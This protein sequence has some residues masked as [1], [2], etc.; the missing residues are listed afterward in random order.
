MATHGRRIV[1]AGLLLLGALCAGCDST[2]IG[3]LLYFLGPE[4]K[5]EP[6][7]RR[8]A[9]EDKSKESKVVLLVSTRGLEVRPELIQADR[10]LAELLAKQLRDQCAANDERLAIIAPRKVEEFKSSHPNWQ[11]LD[12]REIG[13]A[14]GADFVVEVELA[15]LG[16]YEQGSR[17]LFRGRVEVSLSVVEVNRPDEPAGR[18]QAAFLY[19]GEGRAPVPADGE[20]TAPQFRQVFLTHVAKRLAWNFT[21]HS[22]LDDHAIE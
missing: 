16:L 20:S 15:S 7:L 6:E 12:S 13:R 9:S 1:S 21:S 5:A 4:P 11:G 8:L 10:Q 3:S 17:E 14:F 22:P 18:R 19:P 2:T